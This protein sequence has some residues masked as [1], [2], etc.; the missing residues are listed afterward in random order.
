MKS[1]VKK[2]PKLWKKI[3]LDQILIAI[4]SSQKNKYATE[5][6]IRAASKIYKKS[7]VIV[8]S[9]ASTTL[10]EFIGDKTV[11]LYVYYDDVNHY[12]ALISS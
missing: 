5:G 3:G 2:L 8:R 10:I 1:F 12:E 7:I 6:E 4:K 9:N 11:P